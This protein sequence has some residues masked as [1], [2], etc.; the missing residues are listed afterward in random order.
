MAIDKT[1]KWWVGS[2]A[3]DLAEY[4][5]AFTED[6]FLATEFRVA[7]CD[8]GS[9]VFNLAIDS[10]EGAATRTCAECGHTYFICDSEEYWEDA[11]P[12]KWKCFGKCNSKTANVCVG[13]ALRDDGKDVHWIYVGTRCSVCGVLGCYG[14]W[15][16]DY[17]PSLQLM[18]SV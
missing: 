1:G 14:D 12:K 6:G 3:D 16:I 15:K 5:S 7:K 4:L 18:D 2:D 10:D 8:C 17:S 11:S 9:K 13:F